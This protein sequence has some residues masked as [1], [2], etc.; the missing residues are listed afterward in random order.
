MLNHGTNDSQPRKVADL[1][2]E[3]LKT[4]LLE[5]LVQ[6]LSKSLQGDPDEEKFLSTKE[7]AA[8]LGLSRQTVQ[9]K[10]KRRLIKFFGEGRIQRTTVAEC[11]KFLK[12]FGQPL[13]SIK[14]KEA[15]EK[16]RRS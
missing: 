8:F 16:K 5:T 4:L 11:K 10:K 15:E 9:E 1:T 13:S 14:R 7:A 12:E 2:V 3:E 6:V